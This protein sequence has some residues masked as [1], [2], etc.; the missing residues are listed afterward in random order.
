MIYASKC[1]EDIIIIN[2]KIDNLQKLSLGLSMITDGLFAPTDSAGGMLAAMVGSTLAQEIG[3]HFKKQAVLNQLA[4]K[5]EKAEL[6]AFD[7][8]LTSTFR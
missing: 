3:E 7:G 4:G 5:T 8:C 6:T 1:Y 2:F